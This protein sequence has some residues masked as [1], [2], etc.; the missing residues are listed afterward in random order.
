MS[1][2]SPGFLPPNLADQLRLALQHGDLMPFE[3]TARNTEFIGDLYQ[4]ISVDARKGRALVQTPDFVRSFILDR[5]LNPAI[6]EFGL[7]N[8]GIIDPAC[9]T[10]HF[11]V[12]AFMRIFGCWRVSAP[13]L[14]AKTAATHALAAVHGVDLDPICVALTRIR[15]AAIWLDAAGLAGQ[16][17]TAAKLEINVACADSLLHGPDSDGRPPG[18]DHQCDSPDCEQALA[19]LGRRYEAVVANPPYIRPPGHLRD[20]YACRYRSCHGQYSLSVPFAEL[21]FRLARRG[22]PPGELM[23]LAATR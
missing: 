19:I 7:E 23:S 21:C 17:E 13:E 15:L 3:V 16:P 11:L 6:I 2:S 18:P 10:G 5:T 9:G 12:D 14:P 4:H 20:L 1:A 8:L 22:S